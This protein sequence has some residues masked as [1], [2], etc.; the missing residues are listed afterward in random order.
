[1]PKPGESVVVLEEDGLR[2][3]AF[4]VDHA[5]VHAAVGYRFDYQGRSVVVSGDTAKSSNLTHFAKGADILVHEGLAP[6]LVAMMADAAHRLGRPNVEKI[7]RDIPSYHTSPVEAAE[8]ARDAGVRMLVFTHEIPPLPVKA[9]ESLF[10]K[11]VSDVWS[12]P[13]VVGRDGMTFTLAV[14]DERIERGEL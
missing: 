9:M 12:G 6:Q 11:G 13:V 5:P 2:V 4:A 10:L 1:M 3:V 14:G 8:V 7:T